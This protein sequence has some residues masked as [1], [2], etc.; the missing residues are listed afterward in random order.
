M[1]LA[2]I[3][4]TT[5]EI[6]QEFTYH[7]PD[8]IDDILDSAQQAFGQWKLRSFK[9]RAKLMRDFA[10]LLRGENLTFA[11][12]IATEMGCPLDQAQ[13]EIEK[14]AQLSE[15][16]A[17]NSEEFLASETVDGVAGEASVQYNPLGVVFHIAPWNYPY[18]LALRPIIPAVMA[19]NVVVLKHASA[20]PGI[21]TTIEKLFERAGFPQGV[22]QNVLVKGRDTTPIIED[23]RVSMVTIIGSESAGRSVAATAG[24]SI[25]KTILELGGNDPFIVLADA[26]LK[27]AA[28]QG[29]TSRLRNQGQSC[30]AAKR[31]IVMEEVADEFMKLMIQEFE[32]FKPGDPREKGTGFGPLATEDALH[33]VQNQVAESLKLGATILTGGHGEGA[34]LTPDWQAWHEKQ[35]TGYY[36]PPTLLKNIKK[37]MPVYNEEVFGPVAPII[38]VQSVEEAILTANDSVLGLGASLWTKN[39]RLAQTLIPKL[40]SGMV[41]I[42]GMVR[43]SI[44]MP[45]GGVKNSG[46]GREMGRHGILEFVNI[47]SVVVK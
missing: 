33:S 9:E 20:V 35:G 14:S 12:H 15:Y 13:A 25:K 22:V 44:K 18:Y 3:N 32:S 28:R 24:G 34:K 47:K 43:S 42:N 6:I 40:E 5:E 36:Y 19:G 38:I 30:N 17:D 41:M 10:L 45:Y 8:Q 21:A 31:F 4:P 37:I 27:E 11:T 16:Y 29:A 7:T 46:Y 1:T 23:R 39:T 2:S 26:D